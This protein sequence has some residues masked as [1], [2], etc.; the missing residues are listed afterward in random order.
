MVV[1]TNK[2]LATVFRELER[3]QAQVLGK[4]SIDELNRIAQGMVDK[5]NFKTQLASLATR[6]E[7]EL[8]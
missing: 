7:L 5:N 2:K 3:V 8:L 1:D 4:A 6:S